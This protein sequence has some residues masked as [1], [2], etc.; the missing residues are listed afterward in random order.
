[1]DGQTMF[2]S[3]ACSPLRKLHIYLYDWCKTM[4]L[5]PIS[6]STPCYADDTDLEVQPHHICS[7]VCTFPS[8]VS[9]H[10]SG[11]LCT[12]SV[13]SVQYEDERFYITGCSLPSSAGTRLSLPYVA[14]ALSAGMSII[15]L[16]YWDKICCRCQWTKPSFSFSCYLLFCW[17]LYDNTCP[18]ICQ[19]FFIKKSVFFIFMIDP[20]CI[21]V[22]FLIPCEYSE[23][24]SSF[25]PAPIMVFY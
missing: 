12:R 13:V 8:Y 21:A 11:N 5:S 6:L 4:S 1:M 22:S 20:F 3:T 14:P 25:A 2:R 16:S 7:I 19:H 15:P 17:W 10:Y 24:I 18:S 9:L 23:N